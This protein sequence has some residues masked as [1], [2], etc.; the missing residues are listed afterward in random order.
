MRACIA[1]LLDLPLNKV[2]HFLFDN[3]VSSQVFN[4]RVQDFLNPLG[5]M[6]LET[7]EFDFKLMSGNAY[8][9]IFG[10]SPREVGHVTVGLNGKLVHDPHP[11]KAGLLDSSPKSYGFLVHTSI[12][13]KI[14]K[15]RKA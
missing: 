11:S 15:R 5:L 2:P 3:T 12:N 9:L 4:K 10:I 14:K 1:S 13:T 6:Y 7:A 8:H